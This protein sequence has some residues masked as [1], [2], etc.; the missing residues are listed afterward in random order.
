MNGQHDLAAAYALDALDAGERAEYEVHLAG[1]EQ[2]RQRSPRCARRQRCLPRRSP[3]E[4]PS[5]LRIGS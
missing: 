2:C 3:E 1:C 5:G 4:P